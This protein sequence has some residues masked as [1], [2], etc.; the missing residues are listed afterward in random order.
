MFDLNTTVGVIGM[1]LILAAFIGDL[2]KKI[3]EDTVIYNI[4]NIVGASA[5]AYYAYN[6]NSMP[7]LFLEFVW[8]IFASYKLYLIY[9]T[10]TI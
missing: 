8:A 10:K 6:L 1:V 3:T 9:K 4:M 5:L 7:F 2:F